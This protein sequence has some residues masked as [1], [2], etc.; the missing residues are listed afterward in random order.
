MFPHHER[1]DVQRLKHGYS[2]ASSVLKLSIL[3]AAVCIALAVA[4]LAGL[5]LT[6]TVLKVSAT[7]PSGWSEN[8]WVW[9]MILGQAVSIFSLLNY[10]IELGK[11]IAGRQVL[12]WW[13]RSLIHAHVITTD[14]DGTGPA[15]D[16]PLAER[17]VAIDA[18][19]DTTSAAADL[20]RPDPVDRQ[21]AEDPGGPDR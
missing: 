17:G 19:P 7:A 2:A 14:N 1:I 10:L 15:D 8:P 21:H 5:L 12:R 9:A 18:D 3:R 20:A 6:S 16:D 13:R 11:W 4:G